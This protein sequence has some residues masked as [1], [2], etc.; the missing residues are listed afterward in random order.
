MI[1]NLDLS[2]QLQSM[3]A[4]RHDFHVPCSGGNYQFSLVDPFAKMIG[5]CSCLIDRSVCRISSEFYVC[6]GTMKCSLTG[7]DMC[8][9][10]ELCFPWFKVCVDMVSYLTSLIAP[11]RNRRCECQSW[12]FEFC[13]QGFINLF[14]FIAL[15]R[16]AGDNEG[17]VGYI[18]FVFS[19]SKCIGQIC[20]R[21]MPRWIPFS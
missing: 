1:V 17:V 9:R 4:F 16:A 6:E 12:I 10:I 19:A 15:G 7:L 18:R 20:L 5:L 21:V 14:F 13:S 3:I 11:V 2:W 8:S